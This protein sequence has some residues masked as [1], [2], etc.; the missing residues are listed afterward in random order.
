MSQT[1]RAS[2]GDTVEYIAWRHYGTQEARVVERVLEA[3]KG[4]ADGGPELAAGTLVLLPD[5]DIKAE[6]DGVRLW[7]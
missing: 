7:D 5:L 4:L 2:Q 1:Y 6:R 3:N